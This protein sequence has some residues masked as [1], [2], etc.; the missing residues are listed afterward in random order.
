MNS[1][2]FREFGKAAIDLMADYYDSIRTRDVL[3]SVEPGYLLKMLP[4]SAPEE[5][6]N[7]KD[8]L[9]DFNEAIIPG[10]T[11]WHS[12]QF[13]AFYPTAVSYP[14]IVGGLL[15]DSLAV[16]GFSWMS[17]PACT[18]LEVVTMNWLGKLLGLPEEFLNCSDGPGG[19]V[20]QGSASEATLVGLLVAKNKTVHRLMVNDPSLKEGEINAKLVAYTS[21]QCNSSVEKSGLLGSM[22]MRLLKSDADGR[23]RGETLKNAF[24]EDRAQGLIPCYVIANLGTT[25]T[26]AFDPLYE[27]GP[28]CK[29]ANVWLHVD[30]AYAGSAFICPEY[31]VLMKGVEYADSF[32][33]NPHKWM[34][35]NFDCS[36]MWVKNGYD[37][38]NTFDIQRIYLDDVKTN[39]K[40]P[41]YRHWQ[42]PLGRRFRSLKLWTV[43]RIYGA[44]GIR[45]HLRNQISLAQHFAKLVRADDRFL[46]EPEPSMGL[47]CFRLKDGDSAT[48]K[49]LE[50]LTEKKQ[51]YMVAATYRGRYIIRFVVCSHLTT[52]EDIDIS[53]KIIK[54]EVDMIVT[55]TLHTKTQIPALGH[56][57]IKSLCEKSK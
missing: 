40:I 14:G 56:I 39:I 23:L 28:V 21:D 36:A 4:E 13:H 42:I 54:E 38:I 11:H 43:L 48:R 51:I 50:N 34:L 27:L 20:I 8:V 18:E 52:R 15:S 10:I 22:K 47:V 55:P 6:E 24:E 17:S 3:P 30:A 45:S 29:E 9:K 37:L 44:E 46:V 49:L 7:W 25:G 32:D 57:D 2:E 12:P 41:D 53:W 19:G 16:I 5:P 31:R 26:C 1:T 33:F 35:V